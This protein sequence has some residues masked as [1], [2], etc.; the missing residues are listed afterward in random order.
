MQLKLFLLI[1]SSELGHIYSVDNENDLFELRSPWM[2]SVIASSQKGQWWSVSTFSS[3]GLLRSNFV[4]D[5][6]WLRKY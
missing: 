5:E 3:Q 4:W 2:I 1:T 6:T